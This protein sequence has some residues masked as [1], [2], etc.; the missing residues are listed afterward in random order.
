MKVAVVYQKSRMGW[1]NPLVEDS[2]CDCGSSFPD[3]DT[4]FYLP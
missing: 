1:T 3:G 4:S 2:I